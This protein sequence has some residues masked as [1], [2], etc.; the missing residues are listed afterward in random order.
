[1]KTAKMMLLGFVF[2][3]LMYLAAFGLMTLLVQRAEHA[4]PTT[5]WYDSVQWPKEEVWL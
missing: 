1:M 3:L 4:D 2:A 5:L